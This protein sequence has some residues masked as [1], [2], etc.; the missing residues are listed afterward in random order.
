MQWCKDQ[1]NTS[2]DNVKTTESC[3]PHFEVSSKKRSLA[4]CEAVKTKP[5][6]KH[7]LELQTE[8]KKDNSRSVSAFSLLTIF[9][10]PVGWG[11]RIHWLLLCRGVR[12][13]PCECPGYD[14]KQ[15]DVLVPVMLELWGMRGTLS[16][17]SLPGPLWPRV[18]APDRVLWVR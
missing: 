14:T 16:F 2:H 18:V 6:N 8:N 17:P 10:C 15:S 1:L 3:G 11:F 7:V 9:C 5:V 13:P 12:Y 4:Q